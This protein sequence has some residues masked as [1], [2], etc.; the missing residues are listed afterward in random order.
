MLY[1]QKAAKI[2][3]DEGCYFLS[4]LFVAEQELK[5]GL[6][7]LA[8]YEKALEKGWMDEDCYMKDP[9]AM[10]SALLGVGCDVRKSWDFTERLGSNEWDIWNYK[11]EATG[12]TYYHFAVVSEGEVIYDPLGDS[13]T[14]ALGS[15]ASRRIITIGE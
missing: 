10:L 14:I 13:A 4:L 11:R 9:A 6:D 7:A 5:K 15:P 8:V 2:L 12:A 1:K 3:G